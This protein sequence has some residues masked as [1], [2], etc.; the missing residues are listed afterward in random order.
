MDILLWPH[1]ALERACK[2]VQP[3]EFGSQLA[4]QLEEMRSTMLAAGGIGLAANQVGLDH[5]MLVAQDQGHTRV[6][7][8]PRIVKFAGWW[9]PMTEG[10]LSLPGVVVQKVRNTKLLIEYQDAATGALIVDAVSGK[11]AHILQHEIEHLDGKMMID[12]PTSAVK[13]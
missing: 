12:H 5:R 9:K 13:Q 10:C 2:P 11:L 7:V 6:F 1:P 3:D 8:N 4:K